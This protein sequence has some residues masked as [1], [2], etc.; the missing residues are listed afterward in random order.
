MTYAN[1][2]ATVAVFIALGG[3]SYAAITVTGKNVQNSSLT[4][5]DVRNSSL[6]TSDVRNRSLLAQDFRAGQL[7]AGPQGLPGTPGAK[8]DKGDRGIQ[9]ERGPSDAWAVDLVN[10]A[11]SVTL[12]PGDYVAQ[13]VARWHNQSSTDPDLN[14]C[15][16]GVTFPG[17]PEPRFGPGYTTVPPDSWGSVATAWAFTIRD[18]PGG[19]GG[20][21][22]NCGTDTDRGILIVTRVGDLE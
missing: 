3:S 19:G 18:E 13:A 9:G 8:G 2:M 12:P 20:T 17:D 22:V 1:V 16:P 5:R 21:D 6:T 10:G 7:P 15:N 11:A 14:S 4:G